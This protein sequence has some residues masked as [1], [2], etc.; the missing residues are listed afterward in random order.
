MDA[1][2]GD[3]GVKERGGG[4]LTDDV[5]KIRNQVRDQPAAVAHGPHVPVDRAVRRHLPAV[6]ARGQLH[7]AGLDAVLRQDA[8]VRPGVGEKVADDDNEP[9]GYSFSLPASKIGS[10]EIEVTAK[11]EKDDKGSD[12]IQ[13]EIR[14]YAKN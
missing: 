12:K 8:G 6:V 11:N 2:M 14:G 7:E 9:V 3:A 13:F 10:H 4:L 1:M 5:D